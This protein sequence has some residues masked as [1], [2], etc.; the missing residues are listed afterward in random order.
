MTARTLLTTDEVAAQVRCTPKSV[1]KLV[2]TGELPA[3]KVLRQ[4]LVAQAD[5]DTWLAAQESNANVRALAGRS[6]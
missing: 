6:A 1:R 5:L 4:W 2:N 3:T